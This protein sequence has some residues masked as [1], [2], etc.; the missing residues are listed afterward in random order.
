MEDGVSNTFEAEVGGG[1]LGDP[2]CYRVGS[3]AYNGKNSDDILVE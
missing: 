2:R 1:P 3:M